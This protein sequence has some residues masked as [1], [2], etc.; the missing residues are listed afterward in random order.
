M[1]RQ[2]RLRSDLH[3]YNTEY[4]K[5]VEEGALAA[6]RSVS[7]PRTSDGVHR[8]L[9]IF[10]ELPSTPTQS[11]RPAVV[12]VRDSG[13]VD[14]R[15]KLDIALLMTPRRRD[16][17]EGCVATWEEGPQLANLSNTRR[18]RRRPEGDLTR[19]LH[20]YSGNKC[21]TTGMLDAQPTSYHQY[22]NERCQPLLRTRA[23]A[24][25]TIASKVL[26]SMLGVR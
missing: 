5:R 1:H 2:S 15:G 4:K 3:A 17:S 26:S 9:G 16:I 12:V 21:R 10:R 8:C 23:A 22:K 13:R 6:H 20:E 7:R 24:T 19:T 18:Q 25:V 11:A 14:G